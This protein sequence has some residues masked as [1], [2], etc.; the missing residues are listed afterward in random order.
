MGLAPMQLGHLVLN[1]RDL[2][3]AEDFYTRILGLTVTAKFEGNAVFMSANTDL[4]HELLLVSPENY[5]PEPESQGA[6]VHAAWQMASFEDL[7]ALHQRLKDN[8]I[9]IVRIGD[10]GVSLGVYFCDPDGN[11]LETYYELPKSEWE[12]GGTHIFDG[13][14]PHSLE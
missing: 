4:S 1:V 10:H 9:P 2:D 6:L 13:K 12:K 3:R 7:K 8:D 11:E 5:A 14:F